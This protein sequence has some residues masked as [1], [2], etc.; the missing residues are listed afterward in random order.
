MQNIKRVAAIND[1]SGFCRCSLTAAIPIISA[2]GLHCCPFPTAVLSNHT[3]YDS[4]FFDDYTDKMEPYWAEWKKNNLEFNAI[5]TGFLGSFKQIEIVMDFIRYFKND[6]NIVLIDPVMGD[7]GKLYSTY[8]E[9]MCSEMKKLI[10]YADV[11]TPNVTECCFLSDTPYMG[12][13]I[14]VDDARGMCKKITGAKSV[15]VTGIRNGTDIINYIYNTYTKE[16]FAISTKS[17][18]VYYDGTGDVFAS[19]LCGALTCG[20]S[21]CDA[22]KKAAEFVETAVRISLECGI[23]FKE[24]IAVEK[25]MSSLVNSIKN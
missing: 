24:G 20:M 4:F 21:L 7:K 18:D 11:I 12:E 19:V 17:I 3:G 10:V 2:M 6:K 22:V 23:S 1:L 13:S 15:V 9:K 25:C 5:Y 16:E 8:D 14:T